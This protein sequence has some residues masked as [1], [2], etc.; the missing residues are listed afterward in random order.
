MYNPILDRRPQ[1]QLLVCFV[2]R[3]DEI[4]GYVSQNN[5]YTKRIGRACI[6]DGSVYGAASILKQLMR[7]GSIL[8]AWPPSVWRRDGTI[9]TS[10]GRRSHSTWM[11]CSTS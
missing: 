7:C 11:I 9:R 3:F 8:L 10:A 4:V 5:L 6:V 2:N 1:D